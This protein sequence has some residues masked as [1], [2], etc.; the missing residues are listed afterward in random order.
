MVPLVKLR[1]NSAEYTAGAYDLEDLDDQGLYLRSQSVTS[2]V[3]YAPKGARLYNDIQNETKDYA[4]DATADGQTLNSVVQ[5]LSK[6]NK[7][8]ATSL[9]F[10]YINRGNFTYSLDTIDVWSHPKYLGNTGYNMDK[11]GFF[12]P[13][14][15]V[16][17]SKSNQPVD[18]IHIK[19]R[20]NDVYNRRAEMWSIKGA[21]GGTYMTDVDRAEWYIR[22]EFGLGMLAVN[23][24]TWE[25]EAS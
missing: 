14:R 6:G 7:E 18:N 8:V 4:I 19:Y 10:K 22:G 1:G 12:M 17:D 25:Y 3:V 16:K 24:M 2:G 11:K 13:L 21:G 20:S 9:N 23:Q 5:V 15:T